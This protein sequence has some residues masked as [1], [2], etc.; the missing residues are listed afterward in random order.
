[1]MSSE[2]LNYQLGPATLLLECHISEAIL[3]RFHFSYIVKSG[4]SLILNVFLYMAT[5][6]N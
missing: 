5:N 6:I 2:R 3:K 4:F 1:M